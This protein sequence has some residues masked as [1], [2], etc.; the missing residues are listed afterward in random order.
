[1]NAT[2]PE[3]ADI[4]SAAIAE[5]IAI[6]HAAVWGVLTTVD[7]KARPRNRVVHPVWEF[8]GERVTGWL[9]TRRTPLK[10]RHLA[11]NPN[12]SVAYIG[13]GT[14]FAYFDCTADWVE[15][16]AGKQACW[17]AFLSAPEPVRY[18][19]SNIWPEGP[20][21]ETF[22]VLS[23]SPYRIQSARAEQMAKGEKPSLVRL[24]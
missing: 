22:A 11:A 20:A 16:A 17:D 14:D 4:D 15:D 12:V 23:F 3:L 7:A 8:D 2:E 19:P 24:A 13:A 1:M 18:D 9:T 5:A 21:A 6:A 10:T